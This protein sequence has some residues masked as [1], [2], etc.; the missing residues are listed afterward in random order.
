ML[1]TDDTLP[2]RV[3]DQY[4]MTQEMWAERIKIWYIPLALLISHCLYTF[5]FLPFC[6]LFY[7][8]IYLPNYGTV[9]YVLTYKIASNTHKYILFRYNDHKGMGREEAQMEYLKIVQD[10]DMY[11]INYFQIRVC[12]SNRFT[13]A[14][15]RKKRAIHIS[16]IK[17][18]IWPP[19]CLVTIPAC[20]N[21]HKGVSPHLRHTALKT[22]SCRGKVYH[23]H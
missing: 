20:I 7:K 9:V 21:D 12:I 15:K 22:L 8:K 19:V 11:G 6:S 16:I 1:S 18:H 10:L 23:M 14:T 17:L 13:A 3:I 4:Q 5:P 2:Q